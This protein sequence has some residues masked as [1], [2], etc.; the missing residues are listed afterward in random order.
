MILG[1]SVAERIKNGVTEKGS[2]LRN[3]DGQFLSFYILVKVKNST[4]FFCKY[5]QQIYLKQRR[6]VEIVLCR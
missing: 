2:N 6:T 3:R 4:V 5:I 1:I